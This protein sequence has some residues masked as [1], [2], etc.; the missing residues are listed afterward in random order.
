[1]LLDDG[2]RTLDSS[3]AVKGQKSE[4][5]N[6]KQKKNWF[7]LPESDLIPGKIWVKSIFAVLDLEA[8]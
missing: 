8:K 7:T 5:Q 3:F 1:M 6:T 2:S 4:L